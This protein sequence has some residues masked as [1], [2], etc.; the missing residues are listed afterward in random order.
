MT[1]I[2]KAD[3]LTAY[4]AA[5]LEAEEES[6]V[7]ITEDEELDDDGN[8][9]PVHKRHKKDEPTAEDESAAELMQAIALVGISRDATLAQAIISRVANECGS[10]NWLLPAKVARDRAV[11]N[12]GYQAGYLPSELG[13][14]ALT[15]FGIEHPTFGKVIPKSHDFAY[16]AGLKI[17]Q[18][19]FKAKTKEEERQHKLAAEKE[20]GTEIPE[21]DAEVTS[22]AAGRILAAMR[23]KEAKEKAEAVAR[24]DAEDDVALDKS[25]VAPQ[26]DPFSF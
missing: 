26:D 5:M 17:G 22:D 3:K 23:A 7:E 12:I 15:V 20:L 2:V 10:N 19:F 18:E 9:V 4:M 24:G 21:S 16:Q 14:H 25:P 13:N 6:K 11:I 8:P 1:K